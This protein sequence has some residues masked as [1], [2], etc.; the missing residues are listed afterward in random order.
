MTI[1]SSEAPASTSCSLAEAAAHLDVVRE[2]QDHA[3]TVLRELLALLPSPPASFGVNN[4]ISTFGLRY[5]VE[6][7]MPSGTNLRA[8]SATIGGA[9]MVEARESVQGDPYT[10]HELTGLQ[11]GVPFVAWVNVYPQRVAVTG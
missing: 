11:A 4:F 2:Q 7:V 10:R 3:V 8:V 1:L 9:L 6:L 5:G